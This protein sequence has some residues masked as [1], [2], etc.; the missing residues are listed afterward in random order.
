[1]PGHQESSEVLSGCWR[2]SS[3]HHRPGRLREGARSPRGWS[4]AGRDPWGGLGSGAARAEGYRARKLGSCFQ[5]AKV[6]AG[7][8]LRP[9]AGL[10]SPGFAHVGWWPTCFCC[11]FDISFF[12]LSLVETSYVPG[13]VQNMSHACFTL[14]TILRQVWAPPLFHK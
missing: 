8:Q 2:A 7:V 11:N 14:G 1:M 3:G 10:R 5:G 9:S 4:E 6:L 12:N 13:P